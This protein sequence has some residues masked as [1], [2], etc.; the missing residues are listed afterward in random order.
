MR[1]CGGA[2]VCFVTSCSCWG[3]FIAGAVTASSARA[4]SDDELQGLNRQVQELHQA[5]N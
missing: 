2:R 3:C 4:Q 1:V 5:G